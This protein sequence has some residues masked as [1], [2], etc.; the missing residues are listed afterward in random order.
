MEDDIDIKPGPFIG[1]VQFQA[2]LSFSTNQLKWAKAQNSFRKNEE[3][4]DLWVRGEPTKP[5]HLL[6]RH[7]KFMKRDG[8]VVQLGPFCTNIIQVGKGYLQD[9]KEEAIS[10]AR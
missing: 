8:V 5:L 1:D 3:G 9:I 7:K 10:V 2:F 4:I 6:V